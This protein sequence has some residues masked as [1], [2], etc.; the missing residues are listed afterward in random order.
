MNDDGNPKVNF[1]QFAA[2]CLIRSPCTQ[3]PN[4]RP[5][6]KLSICL[7][8]LNFRSHIDLTNRIISTQLPFSCTLRN[9][10]LF[11]NVFI[12]PL[13]LLLPSLLLVESRGRPVIGKGCGPRHWTVCVVDYFCPLCTVSHCSIYGLLRSYLF[14]KNK[15]F[16]DQWYKKRIPFS[17]CVTH[18][19]CR[20][21][22]NTLQ[23]EE[24][25]PR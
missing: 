11:V 21:M 23:V 25:R 3:N 13:S 18:S 15:L 6:Y 22:L 5:I 19:V 9:W 20:S 24:G 2:E 1:S 17:A 8:L 12:G 16:L 7:N 10:W 4:C 14:A